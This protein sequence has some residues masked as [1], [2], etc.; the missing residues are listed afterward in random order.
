MAQHEAMGRP[1]YRG[2][3]CTR[4]SNEGFE[5]ADA[6]QINGYGRGGRGG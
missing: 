3:Q 1:W 4:L 2:V 6:G 5:N